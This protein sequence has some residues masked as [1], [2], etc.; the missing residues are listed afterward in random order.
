MRPGPAD[1]AVPGDDTHKQLNIAAFKDPYSSAGP[2]PFGTMGRNLLSGSAAS[3]WD[4]SL[5]KRFRVREGQELEFRFEMFNTFNHPNFANPGSSIAAPATF[6]RSW[7]AS[8]AR[9]MQFALKY[10]F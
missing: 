6:G 3:N 4:F 5:F 2:A 10:Y 1:Y 8:T 7:A 9:E